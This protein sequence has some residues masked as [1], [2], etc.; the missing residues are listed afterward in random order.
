M[1]T[2]I[3]S[4]SPA[5]LL[6]VFC[7]NCAIGQTRVEPD[8]ARTLRIHSLSDPYDLNPLT[9]IDAGTQ[10][11]HNLMYESLTTV[12]W[13]T[14]ETIPVLAESLPKLS[15]DKL[16]YEVSIRKDARFAD[17]TPV[18]AA[19]FILY[20]KAL[21]NPYIVNA[22][23]SR[24]YYSRVDRAE[25]ID[26]DPYRLRVVMT[27]PYYLGNQWI[28]GLIALPKHIWDPNGLTD[29]MT[30][31]ELNAND[32]NGNLAIT[33]FADWFQDPEKGRSNVFLM[34]SGPYAFESWRRNDR[35]ELVRND[36]YWNK[37]NP[38]FGRAIPERITWVIV[39]DFR[40]A[41]ASLLSDD[42]DFMPNV[43]KAMLAEVGK[44][45]ATTGIR[46]VSYEF[47]TYTYV[48][49]NES[50]NLF[51][52]ARVR[53]ALSH[54]VNREAIIRDVYAGF[55]VPVQSPILRRR[56]EHDS[57]L[58]IIGFDLEKARALLH[59]AGWRDSDGD[60]ILD[61]TI[62][63]DQ[64]DFRFELM[65]NTG[66]Q[67]RARMATIIA[68][69]LKSIGI[70]ATVRSIDWALF[71]GR[72]RDGDYDA[73]IGGWAM[74]VSEGDMYEIW[75]SKSAEH[76]GSNHIRFRNARVDKLIEMIRREFD[77]KK[78]WQYYREIQQIIHKEQPYTF[79]V[80]ERMTGAISRHVKSYA[81]YAPRP[82]YNPAWWAID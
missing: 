79:L 71:L 24:G 4:L 8:R 44:A 30:F 2:L 59:E 54:A 60:G 37:S 47:P 77:F 69:D 66:N 41:F 55:A 35:V 65:V 46:M 33:E 7:S 45:T 51:E 5:L 18:T 49:W 76:G 48:G 74:D 28:G 11:I 58:P 17:G 72:T 27:E 67:R 19:D 32:P 62:N 21:K 43:E 80:T 23:P 50:N 38:K 1:T 81:F 20:L 3:A 36:N 52:D 15:K 25:L 9:S 56:P 53:L 39:N 22:A 63:G 13:E 34:G 12:D 29:R 64:V 78:R 57:T 6:I 73:F 31:D 68:E 70:D 40:A 14:L 61:K 75:H 82:G 42:L 16:S 10:E 26:N